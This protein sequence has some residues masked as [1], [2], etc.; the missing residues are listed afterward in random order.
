MRLLLVLALLAAPLAGQVRERPDPRLERRLDS[1][2]QGFRGQVGIYVRHLPTGRSAAI[3][4]DSVFPT[5]SMIKVPI[6]VAT[7]DAIQKGYL[8]VHQ[9]LVYTDS[10]RY[11]GEDLIG[12]L[13]DSTVVPLSKLTLMMITTSDNTASLWL[14]WLLSLI[15]I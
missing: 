3:H 5:A 13:K 12:G 2:V 8:D 7:F 1:L 6:L 11:P 15:H 14:Q 4:A 9:P 10:L